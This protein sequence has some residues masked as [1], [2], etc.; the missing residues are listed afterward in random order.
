M[1]LADDLQRDEEERSLRDRVGDKEE[2]RFKKGKRFWGF[3]LMV[4]GLAIYL[5]IEYIVRPAVS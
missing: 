2:W 5:I 1:S 3:Y 4:A